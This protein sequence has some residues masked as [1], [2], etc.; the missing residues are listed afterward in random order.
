M[1]AGA[2]ID[3]QGD[4]RD[5]GTQSVESCHVISVVIP[6]FGSLDLEH[7]VCDYN[8]T[9]A[10]DGRLLASVAPLLAELAQAVRVH[11]LTADTHGRAAEEIASLPVELTVVDAVN[12]AEAKRDFVERLGASGVR[13]SATDGTTA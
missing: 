8:G 9:L 11:V 6:G 2:T 3:R 12:Q 10:T 5:N 13:R 7:L 1:L 4:R